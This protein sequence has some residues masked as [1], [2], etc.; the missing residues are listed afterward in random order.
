MKI[1]IVTPELAGPNKNGGI[2]TFCANLCRLLARNEHEV[3][4]LFSE[5]PA[6]NCNKDWK[7]TFTGA[8]ISVLT[9]QALEN[10]D[11]YARQAPDEPLFLQRSR[12]IAE[13][14]DVS[15]F[16]LVHF[17]DW[18]ANGFHTIRLKR[19]GLGLQ[20]T[21][22]AVTLHSPSLWLRQGMREEL[23]DPVA[24]LTLDY[25]ECYCCEFADELIAPTQH[26]LDWA[27]SEKWAIQA[28]KHVLPYCY[29]PASDEPASAPP[30]PSH[31]IFFGRLETR[32]GLR[33]FLDGL[34][35]YLD[36]STHPLIQK[37]TFLGK[38][39]RHAGLAVQPYLEQWQNEECRIQC[40][41]EFERD[42]HSAINYIT[43]TGGFVFLPSLLDNC[44]FAAI[45]CIEHGVPFFAAATGGIPQIV[46]P[47]QLFEPTALGVA[48][49]LRKIETHQWQQNHPYRAA[50]QNQEWIQLHS[51][52]ETGAP[53]LR[54]ATPKKSNEGRSRPKVSVCIPYFNQPDYLPQ[55]LA[56]I[57]QNDYA[58]IQVI[59]C[60]DGSS[61]EEARRVFTEQ[62]QRYAS[63]DWNFTQQENEGVGHARNQAAA[64]ATGEYL[65]FMDADNVAR[66]DMLCK[67]VQAMECSGADGLTCYFTAF[68]SQN[69][70]DDQTRPDFIYRPLGAVPLLCLMENTFGDA[71]CIL[72]R[73][74]FEAI[75]GFR[76]PPLAAYADWDLFLRLHL[77]GYKVDL[78][79]RELF[80]YRHRPDSMLRNADTGR[81]YDH[82]IKDAFAHYPE[83]AGELATHVTIPLHRTLKSLEKRI[84]RDQLGRLKQ[85]PAPWHKHIYRWY[86]RMLGDPRYQ[87]K[88]S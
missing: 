79:P 7:D 50:R 65:V 62:K 3:T 55:A 15:S 14:L 6:P 52:I 87:R 29:I 63:P 82:L 22:I 4:V 74:A 88:T 10:R 1:C 76:G 44:P 61:T 25:A 86:R 5:K 59:I 64:L 60:N 40:V 12:R 36:E 53:E 19:S 46:D 17:Q 66:P 69:P 20:N 34:K 54:K 77:A 39:G 47:E 85:A 83:L 48:R 80:W 30:D 84:G 58:N 2:G 26:M 11:P 73:S 70:P 21:R 75:G 13:Y 18:K 16:D 42:T 23:L 35:A 24:E 67:M 45:E 32:K 8:G 38:P 56:S 37:V 33:I 49:A 27:D 72:K 71:N 28:T 43:Q 68:S 51:A 81:E 78:I 31:V 57:Q 41:N 9:I